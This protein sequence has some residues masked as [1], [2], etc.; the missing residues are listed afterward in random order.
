MYSTM[1]TAEFVMKGTDRKARLDERNKHILE[2]AQREKEGDDDNDDEEKTEVEKQEWEAKELESQLKKAEHAEAL[3]RDKEEH[4]KAAK[5][6]K[7]IQGGTFLEQPQAVSLVKTRK[8]RKTLKTETVKS[9]DEEDEEDTIPEG[10]HLQAKLPHYLNMKRSEDFQAYLQQIV[11]EFE[12]VLI[13][14]AG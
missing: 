3:A 14:K 7:Q 2:A 11:L 12:R 6:S 4:D 5:F 13:L 10:F 8:K 9:A 1:N